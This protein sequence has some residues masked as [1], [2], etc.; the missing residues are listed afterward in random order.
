MNS[1]QTGIPIAECPT[2]GRDHPVNRDHCETCGRASAF[3]TPAGVCLKCQAV[4]A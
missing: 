3:I 2:C 1:T 4:T